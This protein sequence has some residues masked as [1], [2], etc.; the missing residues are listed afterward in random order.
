[1]YK[2]FEDFY[3]TNLFFS[4][5]FSLLLG[6]DILDDLFFFVIANNYLCLFFNVISSINF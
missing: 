6:I 4:L 3:M 5:I 1:M 2:K